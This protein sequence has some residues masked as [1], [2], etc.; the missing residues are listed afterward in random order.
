MLAKRLRPVLVPR[1]R[2]RPPEAAAADAVAPLAADADRAG[3]VSDK[4][5]KAGILL[6]LACA[7]GHDLPVFLTVE[8]LKSVEELLLRQG[9]AFEDTGEAAGSYLMKAVA[10]GSIICRTCR[11]ATDEAS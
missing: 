7:Q 11:D 10:D 2:R 8:Q 6:T 9:V 4:D 3:L 5:A 1:V